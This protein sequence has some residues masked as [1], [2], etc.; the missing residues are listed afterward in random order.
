MKQVERYANLWSPLWQ[1]LRGREVIVRLMMQEGP[2]H[3][4]EGDAAVADRGGELEPPGPESARQAAAGAS[5]AAL[6]V[7]AGP[8]ALHLE[9][10]PISGSLFD[11]LQ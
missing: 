4:A 11:V 8:G 3:M 2:P 7:A 6:V 9:N 5:S 10:S 1:A